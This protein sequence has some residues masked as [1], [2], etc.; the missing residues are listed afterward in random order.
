MNYEID[1]TK[2]YLM[3][4]RNKQEKDFSIWKKTNRKLLKKQKNN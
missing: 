1:T 2:N 4:N 3:K